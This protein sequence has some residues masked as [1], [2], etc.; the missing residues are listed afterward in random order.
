[1]RQRITQKGKK[2]ELNVVLNESLNNI[3]KGNGN[4]VSSVGIIVFHVQKPHKIMNNLQRGITFL[5]INLEINLDSGEVKMNDMMS[6]NK[7]RR[8]FFLLVF[9]HYN[10]V[11]YI[12]IIFNPLWEGVE[13]NCHIA[14][15]I[16][17]RITQIHNY[18]LFVL[19]MSLLQ[20]VIMIVIFL[21]YE[22]NT[23]VAK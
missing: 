12:F 14:N 2:T 22:F 13:L 21:Q 19:V 8:F 7:I 6:C 11:I 23:F 1:M 5:Q 16:H 20:L 10:S 3:N 17:L 15:Q 9:C 18:F 4:K